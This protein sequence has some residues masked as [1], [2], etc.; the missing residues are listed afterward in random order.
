MKISRRRKIVVAGLIAALGGLAA[1][2]T[3]PAA[4][5]GSPETFKDENYEL[6]FD[7]RASDPT[8]PPTTEYTSLTSGTWREDLDGQTFISSGDSYVVIDSGSNSVYRRSGS[9]SFMGYLHDAPEGVLALR[10][11]L[12][13]D[14]TLRDRGV[15]VQADKGA[16]GKVH[17]HAMRNGKDL[18]QV[19]IDRKLSD[20]DAQA[21][22][23]FDVSAQAQTIDRELSLGEKPTVPVKAYW[24][25]R[26][27]DGRHAVSAVEH[28]RHR[29]TAQIQAGMSPRGEAEVQVTFY[30]NPGVVHSSGEPN[31]EA[32]RGEL[33]VAS[34][35]LSSAHAQAFVQA[36]DGQNGDEHYPAWPRT[37]VTLADGEKADVVPDRFDGDGPTRTGFF[38]ITATTLVHVGGEVSVDAIPALAAQLRPI[39]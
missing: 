23:L 28:E 27:I 19:S 39:G 22:N 32:P 14:R 2:L 31:L 35:P 13:G 33:Q 37:T 21:M 29:T 34:E 30:E 20:Q 10:D 3:L 6:T 4:F 36:L 11:Y 25:G 18:F 16:D 26:A 12:R 9:A 24:F 8:A 7:A 1:A 5:A 17:L 15:E 38:V